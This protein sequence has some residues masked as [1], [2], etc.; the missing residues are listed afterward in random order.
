MS[1]ALLSKALGEEPWQRCDESSL[2]MS[3]IAPDVHMRGLD[4]RAMRFV[5]L[6][7]IFL[8]A[9]VAL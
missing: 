5:T 1:F 2:I 3:R 6:F 7:E 9:K 4:L 8:R